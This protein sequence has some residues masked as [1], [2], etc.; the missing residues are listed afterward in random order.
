MNSS[1]SRRDFIKGATALAASSSWLIQDGFAHPKHARHTPS[2]IIIGAGLAGLAAGYKLTQAGWSVT[3]LEARSRIGGRVF[4]HRLPQNPGLVCELGA[5]WVGE[6]HHRI[7]ALCRQFGLK[8]QDHLFNE[9]LLRNGKVT[10]QDQWDFSPAA[11]AAYERFEKA[12]KSKSP[13][14]LARL[15]RY[16]WWTWLRKI[17]YPGDDMRLADLIDS[18]DFGESIRHV[19]AYVAAEEYFR[20]NESS[21]CDFKVTGGNARLPQELT[22]RIGLKSVHLKTPVE[23][24]HQRGSKVYVKS[25]ERRWSADACICTVPARTLNKIHFDPPLPGAQALAADQLQ[26]ARIMKSSV[27]YSERFWKRDDFALITDLTS[28]YY[29]HSTKHQPGKEGI[30]T[31]Y[32]IGD[33]AD[34]LAAQGDKR[35]TDLITRDLVAIDPRAPKLARAIASYAWQ[36]DPYTQGA[37]AV[38]R[39]GQWFTVRPL[40]ERSHG[41]VLFA[42][43]HLSEDWQGFMEG[44]ILTGETAAKHL[45]GK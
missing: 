8:L 26:Y 25:G 9:A 45:I 1:L 3:V 22:R 17:G 36:R 30:L 11:L 5:E 33:K 35:R 24:I 19:S 31:S 18:T 29:F 42:G 39:P 14:Q 20:S 44:A 4:S 15:D 37:Y 23:A 43:E 6:H 40:L 21:E 41:K 10:P 28:H 13:R 7:R 27:L 2:C 32:T 12:Y 38:Y 34:V 16:D